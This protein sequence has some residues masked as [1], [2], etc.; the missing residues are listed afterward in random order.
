[1]GGW[2]LRT[3]LFA[4]SV[5][6]SI[7]IVGAVLAIT[8]FVVT[9]A[10]LTSAKDSA[11]RL[12]LHVE[13]HYADSSAS[14]RAHAEEEGLV[15]VER[16][17]RARVLLDSEIS[18]LWESVTV[19]G[20]S[21]A[22]Y[23]GADR[24]L[25]TSDASTAM[26][27]AE[28][29]RLALESGRASD[30][31]LSGGDRLSGAVTPAHLGQAVVHVPVELP[32]GSAGVLDV[33]YL[34]LREEAVIDAVR[35]DMLLLTVVATALMVLVMQAGVWYVLRL[36]DQLRRAADAIEA[37]ELDVQLPVPG[38]HEIAELARSVNSLVNRL[39]RRADAQ[40]RFIAD[41]SHE[42]ATP[43]A[44]IRGYVNILRVWGA[45]DAELRDE[46]LRAIDRESRRMARLCSDMLSLIRTDREIELRHIRFDI[47]ARCREVLADAA[48]RY[49]DKQLEFVGPE[50]GQLTLLGDPERI[51]E[52]ISILVDNAAKYTPPG[53]EVSVTTRRR[54]EQVVIEVA[55]TGPGIPEADLPN[56]FDRF[57]RSD[58]SRSKE[59]GGFGLGLAIAKRI[60]EASG[61]TIEVHSVSGVGATFTIRLPRARE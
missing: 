39:R 40:T 50:E 1:M 29:R 19:L 17:A 35:F 61:G 6:F 52:V 7:V 24:I 26:G 56:I 22:L 47:N 2:S 15:G 9:G 59:T 58:S 55:D 43:V 32:D 23:E 14:A 20:G 57:Y 41:A 13:T 37:G 48:T 36:V 28:A 31:Q 54:R 8:Y 3:R 25:W 10:M 34:P 51:E 49:I 53:G 27:A 33:V 5:A 60:V 30:P 12:A 38:N 45:E 44:G 16:D 42:L 4:I 11:Q 46:A 18:D 21:V